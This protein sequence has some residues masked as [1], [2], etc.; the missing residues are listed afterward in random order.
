M[1]KYSWTKWLHILGLYMMGHW[2]SRVLIM[3]RLYVQQVHLPEATTKF[4]ET[5]LNTILKLLYSIYF[6]LSGTVG[7]VWSAEF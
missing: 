5:P 6:I 2:T 3:F 4:R 1:T 7:Y